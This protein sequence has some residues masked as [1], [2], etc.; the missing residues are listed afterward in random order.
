MDAPGFGGRRIGRTSR[1]ER[2]GRL[3]I[4]SLRQQV[5]VPIHVPTTEPGPPS[6]YR[7][8]VPGPARDLAGSA[9]RDA[10]SST[11]RLWLRSDRPAGQREIGGY[12]GDRVMC[13]RVIPVIGRPV[14]QRRDIRSLRR[15]ANRTH[16]ARPPCRAR[17]SAA[18]AGLNGIRQLTRIRSAHTPRS[19]L[20]PASRTCTRPP[21]RRPSLRGP[22]RR[23]SRA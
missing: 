3:L 5:H 7:A 18:L 16:G 6:M 12:A 8:A 2:R 14:R 10:T 21:P 9:Q 1:R 22:C 11:K 15:R 23:E 19:A 13:R 17:G 4:R 20:E